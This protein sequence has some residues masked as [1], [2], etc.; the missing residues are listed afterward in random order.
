MKV[1]REKM[2]EHREKIISSASKRFREQG[3]DGIGVADLMKEA[4]LTHGGFYGHFDSKEELVGLATERAL[5]D[6]VAKW[7]RVM[8]GETGDPMQTFGRQYLSLQHW[9]NPGTG[10]L[11]A[12]LGGEVGRQPVTVRNRVT[13]GV[14]RMIKLLGTYTRGKTE[15]ARR[16]KAISA[17]AS[18]VGG[19]ILA[20]SV[21][22]PALA[23][24]ILDAVAESLPRLAPSVPAA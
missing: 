23:E 8:G 15:A 3:F 4:G 20:R 7:E 17:Y 13:E 21:S 19:M 1:S 24:E 22:D 11:F 5:H 12:S 6:S 18:V 10:C 9:R 14:Q 16:R 2:A